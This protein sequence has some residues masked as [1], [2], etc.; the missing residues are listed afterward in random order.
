MQLADFVRERDR[1]EATLTVMNRGMDTPVYDMLVDLFDEQSIQVHETETDAAGPS[2]AVVLEREEGR[3]G[4]AVSSLLDLR[5]AVL[6]VNSD[7]YTTGLRGL[8]EVDTPDVIAQLDEIPFTVTGYPEDSREKLLLIEISRHIEGLAWQTGEGTLRAGFQHLS[9]TVDERGTHRVYRRLGTEVGVDTHVYGLPD[10]RPS[11]PGVTVHAEDCREL[12]RS[13]FVVYRPKQVADEAAAL[14]ALQTAP[15]T[16]EGYWS[17]DPGHV[18]ELD[19]HL[20][21]TY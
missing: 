21:E 3:V 5:D 4:F 14:V 13:W 16:W 6:T 10:A 8:S 15:N 2:D 20:E 18:D 19:R 11:I 17:Y 7:I 12:A 1:Q 9:R